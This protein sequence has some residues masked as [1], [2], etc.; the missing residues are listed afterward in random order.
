MAIFGA[1]VGHGVDIIRLAN[2]ILSAVWIF[3]VSHN[4]LHLCGHHECLCKGAHDG[5]LDIREERP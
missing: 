1:H 2:A 4:G 3:W 5:D